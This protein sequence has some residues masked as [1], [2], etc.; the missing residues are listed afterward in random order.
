MDDGVRYKHDKNEIDDF[1][2][3]FDDLGAKT[4][5]PGRQ[6]SYYARRRSAAPAYGEREAL[7]VRGD[8]ANTGAAR[9]AYGVAA[10]SA[11]PQNRPAELPGSRSARGS[12]GAAAGRPQSRP[13]RGSQSG[14]AKRPQSSS[15]GRPQRSAAG[16]SQGSPARGSQGS[17]AGRAQS[18]PARGTQGSAAGRPQRSAAGRPQGSPARGAQSRASARPQSRPAERPRRSDPNVNPSRRRSVPPTRRTA[19][20][21]EGTKG[22]PGR[23]GRDHRGARKRSKHPVLK[24]VVTIVFIL[25]L[26]ALAAGV[27][28]VYGAIKDIETPDPKVIATDLRLSSVMYDSDGKVI[29]NLYLGDGQR[30]MAAYEQLPEHL[31]DAFVAIEDKTFW[32]HHGFNFVRIAGAIRDSVFNRTSVSGTSTISQQLARNVWL[33]DEMSDR[34]M[35][36]KIQEAYYAVQLENNLQKEE[37]LTD[38]L[39]TISLGYHSLGV[40]AAAKN[41]FNKKVEDLDL[42]ESAALA[43]LPKS[44]TRLAMITTYERG[45]V[46]KDDP[47]LLLRGAAYDYLYNDAILPRIKL[48]LDNMLDQE[49]ITQAEYDAVMAGDLREH[50]KP[51][52]ELVGDS[53]AAFFVDWAIDNVA[54]NLMKEYG[55]RFASKQEAR[56]FIYIKGLE[57]HSTFNRKMQKIAADELEDADNYPGIR[58]AKKDGDGNILD[59]KGNLLLYK[60]S[61]IIGSKGRFTFGEDE[62]TLNADGSLTIHK[63]GR[64]NLYKTTVDGK[65]DVSIEFKDMYQQDDDGRLYIIHGG[66]INV[67][68]GY[69][70]MEGDGCKISAE[71]FEKDAGVIELG[72][73]I[74]VPKAGYTLNQKVIQPQGSAVILNHQNG[75]VYAIVGGRGVKGEMNFNRALEPRQP[76]STMKPLGAYGPAIQMSAEDEKIENGEESFGEYWSPLSIIVDEEFEYQGKVW[77]KNWWGSGYRGPTTLR[78]SVEQSMNINAVKVQLNVGA[79]RSVDFLKKLGITTLVEKGNVNDLNPAALAL[80]GMTNGAK[81]IEMASAYGV[82][83]NA[84]V[85]AAPISYTKVLDRNGDVIL[86]G[87]TDQTQAMDAGTAFIMNDILRTTVSNGIAGSASV[88]GVPVAGKTGTTSD[89]FDAWF[90]GNTPKYSMAVWIGNDVN[91]ELDEGSASAARLWSK[92]MKQVMDGREVGEYPEMPDNVI[93]SSVSGLSDYFIKGTKPSSISTGSS[94]VEICE[95]CGYLAT[96]WCPNIKKE[97]FVSVNGGTSKDKPKYYCYMHNAKPKKYPIDPKKKLKDF[98]PDDPDGSKKKEKEKEEKEEKKKQEQE[99]KKEEQEQKKEEQEKKPDPTPDPAPTP[100]P[101]SPPDTT[102]P[103][104]T[105]PPTAPPVSGAAVQALK[106]ATHIGQAYQAPADYTADALDAAYGAD[107][108]AGYA[109]DAAYGDYTADAAYSASDSFADGAYAAS[110]NPYFY[111]AYADSSAEGADGVLRGRYLLNY[112]LALKWNGGYG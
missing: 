33:Q 48:V 37:I 72:E 59:E 55:D 35:K 81:P 104:T 46:E 5:G 43:S 41:Y 3:Q 42:L 63:G 23:F 21:P 75:R 54:E 76:G 18:R 61:N 108:S 20:T 28:Y 89:N 85:R 97:S 106:V 45:S 56:E 101:V 58:N 73:K 112:Y 11:A 40:S 100:D 74:V 96:P 36:R 65:A 8:S 6:G 15:A 87:S 17:A 27:L 69:K 60:Y 10:A 107:Y 19:R 95:D 83:A 103:P 49:R 70:T 86:D 31:K 66:V 99:K 79:D 47:R 111:D 93:K 32:E 92:I 57:I 24:G 109:A 90:V 44:P 98:D 26:V 34:T 67:P 110:G 22:I 12:Q 82:F 51:T 30:T 1:F 71:F 68:Q 4:S 64:L 14:A 62:A 91:I 13:A 25:I 29:K 80:G 52:E 78:K 94:T 105:E 84:G 53:D 9:G 16:R 2:E 77:P 7:G 102:P 50:L 38:Y 88:S 39:N